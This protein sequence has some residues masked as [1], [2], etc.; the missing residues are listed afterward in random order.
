[1]AGLTE[2][3][4]L[5]TQNLQSPLEELQSQQN[6]RQQSQQQALA[7][8]SPMSA[9]MAVLSVGTPSYMQVVE[10]LAG[11]RSLMEAGSPERL[12]VLHSLARNNKGDAS[13]EDTDLSASR[14]DRDS[15]AS[16]FNP[17]SYQVQH[18]NQRNGN[19]N[20][21]GGNGSGGRTG[22]GNVA[23]GA[24]GI[25]RMLEMALA[26][27]L[28]R[29]GMSAAQVAIREDA[30]TLLLRTPET[31]ANGFHELTGALVML[32]AEE[33]NSAATDAQTP[34]PEL[35]ELI[36]KLTAMQG[37]GTAISQ[38]HMQALMDEIAVMLLMQDM[39]ETTPAASAQNPMANTIMQL[40]QNL[41][42]Q[43]NGETP[44]SSQLKQL[45]NVLMK[46][47]NVGS[48]GGDMMKAALLM[49]QL[50]PDL[51]G[52]IDG[53][54][55]FIPGS[56]IRTSRGKTHPARRKGARSLPGFSVKID[57]NGLLNSDNIDAGSDAGLPLQYEKSGMVSLLDAS[58]QLELAGGIKVAASM[59]KAQNGKKKL[60][61]GTFSWN[62]GND[63]VVM[64]AQ[65]E[66]IVSNDAGKTWVPLPKTGIS[67]YNPG[68]GGPTI[69][70]N[71]QI[72]SVT[73]SAGD[74]SRRV[75][76]TMYADNDGVNI[77]MTSTNELTASGQ[78]AT[79]LSPEPSPE[80]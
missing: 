36:A 49:E 62:G 66:A 8:M 31:V 76:G 6:Q 58:D 3:S 35:R 68:N 74:G 46:N 20:G 22:A 10:A 15:G 72:K 70:Y 50:L 37:A 23:A 28:N 52:M 77:D 71:P 60:K 18:P 25:S 38:P 7:G 55:G 59:A 33:M 11:M 24:S 67:T 29:N 80:S 5:A 44:N 32:L 9:D 1:M 43:R 75:L 64:N 13:G 53:E 63:S 19:G 21:Q 41:L 69:T 73:F 56:V 42:G 26:Q 61:V 51:L 39:Q 54:A 78:I 17:L 48:N 65:G 14:S 16:F 4:R 45:L 40:M 27:S 30:I 47:L 2:L 79:M 57:S 12:S 34:G